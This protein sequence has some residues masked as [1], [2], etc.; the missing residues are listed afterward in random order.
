LVDGTY[1]DGLVI[2]RDGQPHGDQIEYLRRSLEGVRTIVCFNAKFDLHWLRRYGVLLPSNY[3]IWCCQVAHFLL[4]NQ[5]QQYPSL[6][7]ALARHGLPSKIDKIKLEYW[8]KGID[9]DAIP[10]EDL[11][12]YQEDDVRKTDALYELQVKEIKEKNLCRL[13]DLSMQDLITLEEMEWNG[14]YTNLTMS[15]MKSTEERE[16]QTKIKTLLT[17][18]IPNVPVNWS[19][20]QQVSA[21]LFGGKIPVESR[22][23]IGVFKTGARKGQPKFRKVVNEVLLEKLVEPPMG[24]ELAKPG[25]FSTNEDTLR[26]L[27]CQGKAAEIVETYLQ[28]KEVDKLVGTY[29]EGI[30]KK[31]HENQWEDNTIHHSLNQCVVV[32]GRLSS[33]N[34]N[35]QNIDKRVKE[36]FES[37]YGE[38]NLEL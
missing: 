27:N 9:T 1:Y 21:V 20:P 8:D 2:D 19:S 34:P 37:R 13:M 14:L 38:N 15:L 3:R 4:I 10:L 25:Q 11:L 35:L 28:Y 29:Y 26:S 17:T 6:N 12:P 36:I 31:I 16:R 23:Q 18:M 32:T 7:D 5:S 30:P 24:A 22:E 33:S